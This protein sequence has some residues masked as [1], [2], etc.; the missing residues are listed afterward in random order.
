VPALPWVP[1]VTLARRLRTG[2][3]EPA[4]AV[5]ADVPAPHVA[6]AV[7]LRRWDPDRRLAWLVGT[8]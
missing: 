4:L 6:T 1:H 8:A 2:D 7:A 5:L 3:V